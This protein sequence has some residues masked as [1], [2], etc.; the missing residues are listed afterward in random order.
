MAIGFPLY[1]DLSGNNCTVFGGG[2]H[3]LRRV[4]ELLR[5]DAKVTVISPT[6]CEELED[7]SDRG[8][9]RHIPRK[10]FR[11]DCSNSQLCVA[12]TGENAVNIAI[13]TE[14][15]AKGIPVNVTSPKEYGNFTFPRLIVK[16]GVVIS[17]A[18]DVPVSTLRHLRDQ[19]Q[20]AIPEMLE[21]AL[22]DSENHDA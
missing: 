8:V 5:F 15:K 13:A 10:F 18:G 11:G 7:L 3:A 12:A 2:D 19:I 16:D 20:Q 17:I 4:N 14:C 22:Q 9:I 6:L 1:I 21:Q